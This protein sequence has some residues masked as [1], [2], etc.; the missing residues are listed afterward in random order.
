M[1]YVNEVDFQKKAP[2]TFHLSSLDLEVAVRYIYIIYIVML[3]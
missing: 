3:V 1:E 2:S